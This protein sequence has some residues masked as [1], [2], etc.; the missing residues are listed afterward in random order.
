MPSFSP[1]LNQGRV[2]RSKVWPIAI[3][4]IGAPD[5]TRY[6]AQRIRCVRVVDCVVES[7]PKQL[8]LLTDVIPLPR[9]SP[10]EVKQSLG[11]SFAL[12]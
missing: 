10:T 5:R 6:S 4:V 7:V 3:I 2:E 8:N 12:W 9:P 1:G 11:Y